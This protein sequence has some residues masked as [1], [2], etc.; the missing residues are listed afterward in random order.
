MKDVG[1]I[2]E[3]DNGKISATHFGMITLARA[4][5][6][7]LSAFV[8]G[9]KANT[10]K[11]DLES[12][13]IARI[14]DVSLEVAGQDNPVVRAQAMANAV[15]ELEIE[16]VFALSHAQGRDLLPR[17]AALLDA[18]LVMDCVGVDL[19]QGLAW[20][21]Q[22][23]GKTMATFKVTG[24]V[25][26]FGVR[27]NA[28]EPV[29]AKVAAEILT[30]DADHLVSRGL[31]VIETAAADPSANTS[32]A[33]ADVIIAGGRGMGSGENFALLY[34]CAEKLNA[35]VGAS[36]VA[37]DAGWVPYALQVGQTGEKVSP[38]V[39]IA[40]GISGSVQHLAGMKTTQMVIAINT[41][42]TAAIMSNC[43]YFV[44][45]DALEIVPALTRHLE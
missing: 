35:V 22:Y 7:R 14:F 2:I 32:L 28:V 31:R 41:D 3:A 44:V 27:P 18:P 34:Q 39:Y 26:M 29:P 1:I 15:R 19:D 8:F 33:E 30:Y 17:I 24:D 5:E 38:R 21:S 11:Q 12:I 40:C 9:A 10:V 16:A 4:P 13:G 36:R 6:T 23:S 45:G 25:L 20:T 43:D 42:D 37:V